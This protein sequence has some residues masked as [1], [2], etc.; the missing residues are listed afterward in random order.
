MRMPT[1]FNRH[2]GVLRQNVGLTAISVALAIANV[3]LV[4]KVVNKEPVVSLVPPGLTEEAQVAMDSADANYK[5]AWGMF[6][7]TMAGNVTPK[8]VKFVANVLSAYVD[9]GIYPEVRRQLFALAADPVFSQNGGSVSFRPTGVIY[10]D[11]S[12]KVFVRGELITSTVAGKP[13]AKEYIFE[14]KLDI[15]QRRPWVT[16]VQHYTGAERTAKWLKHRQ[17]ALDRKGKS[18]ESELADADPWFDAETR[19]GSSADG[20]ESVS[21]QSESNKQ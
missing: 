7:A 9:A 14:W 12:G 20:A 11:P 16:D 18:P 4:A 21:A 2:K 6:F 3:M 17:A 15:R 5:M 19:F 10:D 13:N 8:N 1:L